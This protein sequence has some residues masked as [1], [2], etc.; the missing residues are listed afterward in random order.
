MTPWRLQPLRQ[1]FQRLHRP[2]APRPCPISFGTRRRW[3]RL[4]ISP[5]RVLRANPTLADVPILALTAHALTAERVMALRNGFADVI[6]KPCLPD[7]L[8]TVIEPYLSR[9]DSAPL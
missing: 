9:A 3:P 4:E 5:L 6:P 7:E 8:V 1:P 2:R